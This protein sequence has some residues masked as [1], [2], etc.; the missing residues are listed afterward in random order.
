[1]Q[2]IRPMG[3][4]FCVI[5]VSRSFLRAFAL[6]G[7]LAAVSAHAGC[8]AGA[9]V[10]LGFAGCTGFVGFAGRAGFASGKLLDTQGED[11][12]GGGR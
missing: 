8:L 3:R 11:T 9:A 7:G 10:F 5:G 6:V 4:I 12:N 1:M 2:K